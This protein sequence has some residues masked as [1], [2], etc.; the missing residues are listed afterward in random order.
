[1]IRTTTAA[2]LLA[3]VAATVL[4]TAAPAIAAPATPI[5]TFNYGTKSGEV[6]LTAEQIGEITDAPEMS[7]VGRG[8]ELIDAKSSISPKECLSAFEPARAESFA[9]ADPTSVTIEQLADGKPGKAPH[10]VIQAVIG[11]SDKS[12]T[13]DHLRATARS[14]KSCGGQTVTTTSKSGDE[15]EWQLSEPAT[16]QDDTILVISQRSGKANCERAIAGYGAT[17]IDVMSCSF[18]GGHASGQA[19]DIAAQISANLADQK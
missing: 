16:K 12:E 7:V 5:P 1:M 11:F 8:D 15:V 3:G 18:D 4:A 13:G 17:F 2:T 14:W 19:E 9:D 6:L 10:V